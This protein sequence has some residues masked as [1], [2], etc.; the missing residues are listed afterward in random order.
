MS[1][2]HAS[3]LAVQTL[4]VLVV[5]GLVDVL[6]IGSGVERGTWSGVREDF[7]RVATILMV[8][9]SVSGA[10]KSGRSNVP[11]KQ[12]TQRGHL[13]R[14]PASTPVASAGGGAPGVK[15]VLEGLPAGNNAGVRVVGSADE[16]QA[17][18]GRLSSGG[19]VVEGSKYPGTLIELGDKTTVGLRAASRS[20]GPTIDI[21]LPSGEIWKVHTL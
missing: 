1:L 7:W 8:T 19:K 6:R 4:S 2:G 16:L 5:D 20:G 18:F 9:R 11:P 13:E 12:P 15:T 17:V 14:A 21:K 3:S 10:V